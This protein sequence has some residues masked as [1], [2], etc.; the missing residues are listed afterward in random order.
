MTVEIVDFKYQPEA[1][2]VKAGTK[3]TWLNR[4]AAPHTATVKDGFDTGTL[5]KGERKTLTLETTGTFAYIC[6]IHPF[7]SAS[8]TVK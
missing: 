1:L 6:T 5:R 8:V 7:M 3:V 4:D 2:T